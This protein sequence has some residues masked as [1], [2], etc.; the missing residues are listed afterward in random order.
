MCVC[1]ILGNTGV[2]EDAGLV[3]WWVLDYSDQGYL[4]WKGEGVASA[5]GTDCCAARAVVVV[6]LLFVASPG[7]LVA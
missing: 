7:Q 6:V 4:L 3:S 5:I 2:H 1:L